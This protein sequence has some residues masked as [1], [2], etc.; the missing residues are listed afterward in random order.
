MINEQTIEKIKNAADIVDV[1]GQFVTLKKRGANYIGLCPFH[2]DTSPS[3]HVSPSRGIC[4]CFAC[5]E[6]GDAISFLMKHQQ[7]SFEQAIQWMAERYNVEIEEKSSVSRQ[8]TRDKDRKAMMEINTIALKYFERSLKSAEGASGLDYFRI[9]GIS[10]EM[11]QRFHLGYCPQQCDL[12]ATAKEHG[13]AMQYLFD[14]NAE[15]Y[16]RSSKA[17]K[18]RN[19]VGLL[20]QS[21]ETHRFNCRFAGRAIFP[22]FNS[23]GQI[24][25]FGGRKLAPDTH[26]VMRKYVNSPE[27]LI[28]HKGHELYGLF[29]S[30]HAIRKSDLV[31]L[32]EGYLDVISLHQIGIENVVACS[33]TAMTSEQVQ[34]LSRFTKNIVLCYDADA[35]GLKATI[36]SIDILL[37]EGMNV[38]VL[39][40][41][42]DDDPD[43][44]VHKTTAEDVR[45]YFET[46]SQD[47][48][49]FLFEHTLMPQNNPVGKTEAIRRI[50]NSISAIK[51][52]ICREL[53]FQK[54]VPMCGIEEAILRKVINEGNKKQ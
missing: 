11:I 40:L 3:F 15:L 12:I 33:G 36:R 4:K 45:S 26:D 42:E 30:I 49:D 37:S 38:Q 35:A 24:V 10:D 18:V 21:D 9:R 29:Q 53:Y 32:V 46:Q 6:G 28:Y 25:A 16:F 5:G 43:T 31:Y 7:M 22:W 17:N 1:V 44:F 8:T 2:E 48:L 19:G 41:P 27:S 20:Y 52:D 14:T 23:F 39:R 50:L 51:D 54:F 47:F 13:L 34:L